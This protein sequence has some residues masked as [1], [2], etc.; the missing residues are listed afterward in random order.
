MYA[1]DVALFLYPSAEDIN[2]TLD[3][4]HLFGEASGH[5]NNAEKSNVYPIQC[6]PEAIVEI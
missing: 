6:S 2:I 3:I 5:K 1:D 4:L